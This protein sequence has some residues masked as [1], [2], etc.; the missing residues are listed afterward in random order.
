MI[1]LQRKTAILTLIL[2]ILL[3][4][5]TAVA[6]CT[7]VPEPQVSVAYWDAPVGAITHPPT[8]I[9]LSPQNNGTYNTTNIILKVNVGSQN[10]VIDS[11][12]YEADWMEGE[13]RIFTGVY[14]FAWSQQVS[15]NVNFTAI[16]DG[17][18]NITVYANM[19][20][21][22]QYSFSVLFTTDETPPKIAILSLKD[23][24]YYTN[25]VTLAFA[26]NEP[27]SRIEYSLDG[28]PNVTIPE[29]T[30]LTNLPYG[31]HNVTVYAQ[32]LAGHV[33]VSDTI[34]F[35]VDVPFPTTLVVA[36][37]ITVSVVDLGIVFY[38]KKRKH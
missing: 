20:N 26:V 31:E 10:W 32:D 13:H 34:T 27:T 30:T 33:G 16:P 4:S 36:S 17:R 11:V 23:E 19:H 6:H 8:I 3:A 35:S 2:L 1:T 29:N 18:H 21:R 25:D 38:F 37:V 15:I 9:I 12:F 7:S 28:E 22:E 5:V 14:H 24:I